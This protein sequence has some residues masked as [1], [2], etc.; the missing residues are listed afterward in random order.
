MI[1]TT[2]DQDMSGEDDGLSSEARELEARYRDAVTSLAVTSLTE[3]AVDAP[4]R[5][6]PWHRGGHG[7]AWSWLAFGLLLVFTILALFEVLDD[8]APGAVDDLAPGPSARADPAPAATSPSG[9]RWH[10]TADDGG[11]GIYTIELLGDGTS[12]P[13]DVLEDQTD[14]GTYTWAGSGL[15]IEFTRVLTLADGFEVT[16]PSRLACTGAPDAESLACT[17]ERQAWVY[18]PKTGLEVEGTTGGP[19]HGEREG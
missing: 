7:R 1:I 4:S 16:E 15:I 17:Y 8:D 11:A 5:P 19:C 13:I 10:F 18:S 14:V 3:P 2:D 6:R 12:G 9:G